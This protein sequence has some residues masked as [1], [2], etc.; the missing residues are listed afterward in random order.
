VPDVAAVTKDLTTHFTSLTD[1]LTNIKDPASAEAAVPRLTELG[2]KLEAA[3]ALVDKLP[4]AGKNKVVELIKSN[5]AKLTDQFNRVL[6]IP[7]ISEKLRPALEGIVNKVASVAGLPAKQFALPSKEVTELGS[8][9]SDVVSSV[10]RSLTGVK[11]A[12][13]AEA[14]LPELTKA[15][16]K[17]DSARSRWDS[18]SE[19]NQATIGSVLK[20]ALASLKAL[21]EKVL[22]LAGVDEKVGKVIKDIMAKLP[23][24]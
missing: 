21:V 4:E 13:T 12:A 18:M 16:A 23:A 2:A 1:T 24:S 10:T 15:N 8:E 20:A 11:D 22:A 3:K 14:A 7:G 6:M 5:M 19:A 17:L 9:F